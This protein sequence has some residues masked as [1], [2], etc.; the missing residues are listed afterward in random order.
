[1]SMTASMAISKNLDRIFHTNANTDLDTTQ[2]EIVELVIKAS[3]HQSQTM[4][5]NI[6]SEYYDKMKDSD[7]NKDIV[8]DVLDMIWC[9][10]T[11]TRKFYPSILTDKDVEAC[12][13]GMKLLVP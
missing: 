2:D 11:G 5:Y 8:A 4:L 1:M 7:V 6:V 13:F 9:G 3:E 12:K 10:N